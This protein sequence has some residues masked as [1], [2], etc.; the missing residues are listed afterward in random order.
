ML[1][2]KVKDKFDAAHRLDM[3]FPEGHP[4]SQLHGHT[5]EV[6]LTVTEKECMIDFGVLKKDLRSITQNL[7]HSFLN[8]NFKEPTCEKIAKWIYDKAR[9][10][11][12]EVAAVTVSEGSNTS[13]TYMP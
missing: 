8:D 13:A 2:L 6:E 5:W 9:D 7:D 11:S 1:F 10:L 12:Y 3:I 4:C